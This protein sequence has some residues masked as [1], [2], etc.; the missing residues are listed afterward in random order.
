MCL[1]YSELLI[2]HTIKKKKKE[3]KNLLP[4]YQLLNEDIIV[5]L[6]EGTTYR[7]LANIDLLLNSIK[8]TL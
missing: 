2:S 3:K 1:I 5:R 6:F 7:M 4:L 8:I